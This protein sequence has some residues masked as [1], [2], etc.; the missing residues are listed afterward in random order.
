[1]KEVQVEKQKHGDYETVMLIEECNATLQKKLP[2]KLKDLGR[3]TIPRSIGNAIFER[4]LCDWGV[5]I[6]LMPL[7][8]FRKLGIA[9]V[10]PTTMT[11][12]LG[13]RS[14][15]H[16]KRLI[17]DMLVKVDKFIFPVDFVVIDMEEDKDIPLI[18]GRPLLAIC[19][20]LIDG[21]KGE[22]KLRE[23]ASS[24]CSS[25]IEIIVFINSNVS[26]ILD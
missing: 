11:L 15:K 22:L 24:Q 25:S 4:A 8:I 1:M 12:Q 21:Q 5:S 3:F 6:N 26:R 10:R 14:L 19:R 2:P 16:P 9:E 7:F 13:Y 23:N 17:E 18:L 20:A